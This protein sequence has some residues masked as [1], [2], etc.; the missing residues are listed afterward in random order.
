MILK[1]LKSNSGETISEVLVGVLIVG[2]A[3]VLF[4][5]M[6]SVATSTSLK[7]VD[8]TTATYAQMTAVDSKAGAQEIIGSTMVT[9]KD[10]SDETTNVPLP[11]TLTMKVNAIYSAPG[12]SIDTT[13]TLTRYLMPDFSGGA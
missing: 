13:Y 4:A 10:A 12:G 11:A 2:L 7:S 3:T 6:I 5:T 1:R 8:R 9:L